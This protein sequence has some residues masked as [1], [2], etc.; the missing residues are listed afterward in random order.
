MKISPIIGAI[1]AYN[2]ASRRLS[3]G[4]SSCPAAISHVLVHTGQHYDKAMSDSFFEDLKIPKPDIFLGVGSGTHAV[5]TSEVLRRFEPVLLEQKPDVMIVVGDVNS[6][7]ACALVASK[8]TYDTDGRRPLIAHVEAGLRSF[9]RTMPE[10]VNRVVTDHISDLLFVTEPSGIENLTREGIPEDKIFFVG[11][12]MIDTLLLFRERASRSGV[13]Q[14]MGLIEHKDGTDLAVPYVL[15]TL[16]RPSNV[17]D[18]DT[19]S[20]ILKALETIA[21]KLPIVFPA[22]PRTQKQISTFQ[23]RNLSFA[24][25]GSGTDS[26]NS[27]GSGIH[28][29]GPVGY[30]DFLC[31]MANAKVVLTDSG[32]IQEE[33]TCLGVPCVTIREN[34]ERPITVTEGTNVISGV[35]PDA[36]VSATNSQLNREKGGSV[37]RFWDGNASV[38]ILDAILKQFA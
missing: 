6:T 37:P 27:N 26:L 19:F 30:I 38:R 33:T 9:D 2:C 18:K 35:K 10:E 1:D 12:T 11:N 24:A 28:V 15:L 16:H 7:V 25:S 4:A 13:L 14:S 3:E 5:Q 20:G 21:T 34:T 36:I 8:I 22:H 32:G 17:D 23:L 29:T 31:L